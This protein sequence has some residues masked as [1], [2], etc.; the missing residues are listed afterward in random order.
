MSEYGTWE[1]ERTAMLNAIGDSDCQQVAEL[2]DRAASAARTMGLADSAHLLEELRV[3]L[4]RIN[5]FRRWDN[6][7][8]CFA[9]LIRL[10]RDMSKATEVPKEYR[11]FLDAIPSARVDARMTRA[12][13]SFWYGP[14]SF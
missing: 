4:V 6:G 14:G 5:L 12:Q 8:W 11:R 10:I 2:L 13:T 9:S 7:I 3:E 1:F